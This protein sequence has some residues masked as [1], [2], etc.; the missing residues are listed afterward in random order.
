MCTKI[1]K[2]ITY[3]CLLFLLTIS[4][5]AMEEI[6]TLY[7]MDNGTVDYKVY[8]CRFASL[9]NLYESIIITDLLIEELNHS[10]LSRFP[11]LTNFKCNVCRLKVIENNT[12]S[13]NL[14]LTKLHLN[15]NPID[16]L[17]SASFQGLNS[18]TYLST[19]GY[20]INCIEYD[21][22]YYKLL[23][24]EYLILSYNPIVC[25]NFNGLDHQKKL[26]SVDLKKTNI[27]ACQNKLKEYIKGRKSV[28]LIHE[29]IGKTTDT[30]RPYP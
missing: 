11:N 25:F 1:I 29:W 18:L 4:T 8:L 23:N 15:F 7:K 19:I 30:V 10:V 28:E 20:N 27:F 26:K 5:I 17:Q 6:C 2:T 12:F 24:L 3:K 21:F 9:N 14:K 13:S 22:F 16:K